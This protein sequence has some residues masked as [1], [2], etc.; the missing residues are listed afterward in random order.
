MKNKR[1]KPTRDHLFNA[2]KEYL[3]VPIEVDI[4]SY[5]IADSRGIWPKKRIVLGATWFSLPIG[6][7]EAVLAHEAAHCKKFHLEKRLL[8]LPLL[9]LRPAFAQSIAQGQELEADQFACERGHGAD[10]RSMLG[11]LHG[12]EGQFYPLVAE[13]VVAI[14]AYLNKNI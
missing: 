10:L 1:H 2:P 14:T 11:R 13:R 9:F 12:K 5:L 8:A 3:G 7:R 6:E 4:G